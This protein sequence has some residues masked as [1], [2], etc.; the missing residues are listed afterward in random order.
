MFRNWASD[1]EVTRFLSWP[2][3]EHPGISAA[4]VEKWISGY[5]S[6]SFYHW[7][8]VLKEAGEPIGCISVVN[9]NDTVGSAEIGYC[10]GR[11]WC[12]PV[13]LKEVA[14]PASGSQDGSSG[15]LHPHKEPM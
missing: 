10:M 13:G 12:L 1:S 9:L 4:I 8:I 2:T 15:D 3:H 7:M 11:A 5:G 6:D 14:M